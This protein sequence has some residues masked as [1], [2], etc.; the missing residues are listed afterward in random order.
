MN[1]TS[2]GKKRLPIICRESVAASHGRSSRQPTSQLHPRCFALPN[3]ARVIGNGQ[4]GLRRAPELFTGGLRLEHPPQF[5]FKGADPVRPRTRTPAVPALSSQLRLSAL[6]P[7]S[8]PVSPH[9]RAAHD[10]GARGEHGQFYHGF[11]PGALVR[12]NFDLLAAFSRATPDRAAT[13]PLERCRRPIGGE[14]L[15]R[16]SCT[17]VES[18]A[19]SPPFCLGTGDALHHRGPHMACSAGGQPQ[20]RRR[21]CQRR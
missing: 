15:H 6:T 8:D 17:E 1:T 13:P 20:Q 12:T 19:A 9:R 11:A 5:V 7:S 18:L 3:T 2:G 21:R 16:L 4:S 10:S 14:G